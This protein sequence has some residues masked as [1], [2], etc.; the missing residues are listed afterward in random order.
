M[1]KQPEWDGPLH[2]YKDH[3][4]RAQLVAWHSLVGAL[5]PEMSSAMVFEGSGCEIFYG[6]HTQ[7]Y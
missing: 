3:I 7:T 5:E 4:S 2:V 1:L 6:A